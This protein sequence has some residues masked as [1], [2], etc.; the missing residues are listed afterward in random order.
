M[1][2]NSEI[3]FLTLTFSMIHVIM[4]Y[5][6]KL[7]YHC[8]FLSSFASMQLLEGL[9]WLGITNATKLIWPLIYWLPVASTL[10]M[11]IEKKSNI[12]KTY[13]SLTFILFLII[14]SLDYNH[15]DYDIIAFQGFGG[16]LVWPPCTN[17]RQVFLV[18]LYPF[19]LACPLF[20][21]HPLRKGIF[22]TGL[23]IFSIILIQLIYKPHSREFGSVWCHLSNIYGP[24][25]LNF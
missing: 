14:I 15:H 13:F 3:S 6:Y 5:R 11:Y 18:L 17:V 16:H 4:L 10:G 21:M 9:I 2:W 22:Y 24:I 12:T 20:F 23:G 8:I 7:Y 25:S 1:C 19:G